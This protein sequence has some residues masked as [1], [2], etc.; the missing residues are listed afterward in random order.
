MFHM[1]S[2]TLAAGA[3]VAVAALL[4]LLGGG[5]TAAAAQS[6]E[7]PVVTRDGSGQTIIRATRV[8]TPPRI[9]GR[10]DDAVYREVPPIMGFIQQEPREG[11]PVT[12]A[13]QAW[14]MFDDDNI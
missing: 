11:E 10:L 2:V 14:V 7:L 12:E 9:D 4:F 5:V 1:A 6:S 13:T 8:S 3:H